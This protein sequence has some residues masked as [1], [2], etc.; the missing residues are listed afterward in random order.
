MITLLH[1][2]INSKNWSRHCLFGDAGFL[3]LFRVVSSDE[4]ANPV[5]CYLILDC[6]CHYHFSWQNLILANASFP[7]HFGVYAKHLLWIS[8]FLLVCG[9]S[10][11]LPYCRVKLLFCKWLISNLTISNTNPFNLMSLQILTEI[12][13]GCICVE[14]CRCKSNKWY[15]HGLKRGLYIRIWQRWYRIKM[16]RWCA[17]RSVPI[18][19]RIRGEHKHGDRKSYQYS[20][21]PMFYMR[22]NTPISN[23][24]VNISI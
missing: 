6:M 17:S 13:P 20:F 8:S 11:H 5:C 19:G 16:P 12:N 18:T 9:G 7:V 2:K 4:M 3:Q 22:I 14:S 1:E 21:T 23:T 10:K 15:H 24:N